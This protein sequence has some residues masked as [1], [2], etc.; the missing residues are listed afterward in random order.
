MSAL[1]FISKTLALTIHKQQVDRFGGIQGLRDEALLESALGAAQQTW[2]YSSDIFQTAAQ[3][4]FSLAGNH[5]RTI[6]NF[7]NG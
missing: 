7:T 3:Y 1:F 2:H 6:P 4:C 5:H